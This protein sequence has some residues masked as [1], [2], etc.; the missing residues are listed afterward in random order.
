MAALRA[1]FILLALA[2]F[3]LVGAPLQWLITR[4]APRAAAWIPLCFC[5]LL[6]WLLKIQVSVEG[7]RVVGR[8]VLV[9][10]NHVSWIDILALGGV[11]PFCFLAKR[12]VG[13]WPILSAFANV[14]GTVFVDRGRRRSIPGANRQ[15]A[16]RMRDGRSVLLFPEGTTGGASEP[17]PFRSSHFAAAR[18][19]L[20]ADSPPGSPRAVDVQPVAVAYSSP[21]AAWIGD[22]DLVSHLWRTLR[23]PPIR[24]VL[25]FTTPIVYDSGSDRKLVA[26]LARD[27][28]VGALGRQV[29]AAEPIDA[30]ADLLQATTRS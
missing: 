1:F 9:A 21:D 17:G 15:M 11:T 2:G 13:A 24:C 25:S 27:S 20:R 23:A 14:Q 30:G 8:P 10:A 6:L 28:I 12:E 5:R 19:L 3:F 16:A 4:F 18:E 7:Q 22:D 29:I 26:R